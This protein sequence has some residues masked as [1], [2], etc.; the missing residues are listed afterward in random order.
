MISVI[1]PIYNESRYIAAC[2]DA[3]VNQDYPV[4]DME[5]LF[6]DGMS[7]DGTRDIVTDYRS[8]YPYIHLVDNPHRTVPYAMNAGI[9]AAHGDVVIRLDAHASYPRNYFS[10]LHDELLRLKADNVGGVCITLPGADNVKAH[11]IAKVLSSPFGMGNS[12]FRIG[13]DQ[14][15]QV[16]TV[17]FGCFPREVFDR[18][19]LYDTDLVRNQ[20]DEL[21]ARIINNGG[22]IYLIPDLTIE[23]FARESLAKTWRMFYQYGLYKPLVAKKLGSPATVRQFVPMI[24]VMTLVLGTAL[25]FAWWGFWALTGLML[26]LWLLGAVYF[27]AK[28]AKGFKDFMWQIVTFF[29]VHVAYGCG[30]WRGLA[31]LLFHLPFETRASR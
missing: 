11:A 24:F 26:G 7:T 14:V 9:L 19:G 15:R 1:C 17:P 21:N 10:R 31:N 20:D 22:K 5:V 8:R 18:V 27:A 30:Y 2:I 28:S 13:A 23:Y 29:T 6:V 4:N 25:G 3:V 16:D 12:Y